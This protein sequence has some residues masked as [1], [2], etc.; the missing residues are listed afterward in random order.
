MA[1]RLQRKGL[2]EERETAA[3]APIPPLL[4]FLGWV[5]SAESRVLNRDSWDHRVTFVF[6]VKACS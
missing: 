5:S 4:A 1:S 2:E 6:L 3:Q